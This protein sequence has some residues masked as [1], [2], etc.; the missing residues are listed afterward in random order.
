MNET[1]RLKNEGDRINKRKIINK[2]KIIVDIQ[3]Y[4]KQQKLHKSIK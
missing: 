2:I 1:E 3:N 4:D